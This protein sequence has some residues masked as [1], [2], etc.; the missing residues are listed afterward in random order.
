M[1]CC[2]T[3]SFPQGR[4]VNRPAICANCHASIR[5]QVKDAIN[6]KMKLETK[7]GTYRITI[8]VP[9]SCGYRNMIPMTFSKR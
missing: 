2:R 6:D 1:S 9:C 4:P 5:S 8:E 3:A 7:P